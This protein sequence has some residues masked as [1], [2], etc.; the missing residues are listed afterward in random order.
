MMLPRQICDERLRTTARD[1]IQYY[2]NTNMLSSAAHIHCTP[3]NVVF[4]PAK[5]LQNKRRRIRVRT[6]YVHIN[7]AHV[8]VGG[9]GQNDITAKLEKPAACR[10]RII[11]YS[12]APPT[13]R[14]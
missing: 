10:L 7:T 9:I 12:H 8:A 4:S 1:K 14:F 13:S 5:M 11:N 2:Y 3:H 6:S